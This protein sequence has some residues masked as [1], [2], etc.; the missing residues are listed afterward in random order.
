MPYAS[1]IPAAEE[2]PAFAR[3]HRASFG[4]ARTR[5]SSIGSLEEAEGDAEISRDL[6]TKIFINRNDVKP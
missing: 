3:Y 4:G 5:P 2:P 6:R 1:S